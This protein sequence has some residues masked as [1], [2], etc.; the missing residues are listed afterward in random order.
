M[1]S[2]SEGTPKVPAA[3]ERFLKQ[4]VV[5][6][7]AVVLYPPASSIPQENAAACV[8]LLSKALRDVPEVR[9]AVNKTG[10][11]YEGIIVF[12]GQP[13][14]DSFAQEMYNRGLAEVRF[15]SGVSPS[16]VLGF[17]GTLALPP[18]DLAAAGGFESRLWESGVDA[19]TVKEASARIV[20]AATMTGGEPGEPGEPWPPAP[21]RIDEILA[22]AMGGRPRDQ[23]LIVRVISDAEAVNAY[24]VQT[25]TGR[26]EDPARMLAELKITELARM[27]AHAEQSMRPKLFR[28]LADAVGMLDPELRK[29]VLMEKMLPEARSDD[30][31]A[32]VVRQ[33]DIGEVCKLLVQGMTDD[34]ASVEGLARAIRN[35]ALISLADRDQVIDAAGAAMRESGLGES[36]IGAVFEEVSPTV[37]RVRDRA[38]AAVDDQ[39]VEQV[40]RLVDLAPGEITH[41]FDDDPD[42]LALQDEA[43]LG[44]NDGD[45]VGAL[46]T[47]VAVDPN[48]VNFASMMSLLEDNLEL[49]IERGDYDVAADVAQ[50]LA[51]VIDD[52]DLAPERKE[53]ISA[54]LGKLT[55]KA[56]IAAVTRALRMY[57]PGSGEYEAC[58]RLIATL[59]SGA[60]DPLLEVL[61]DEPDM[62]ARKGLV[63][64][65]SGM[66]SDYIDNLAV[67][68]SDPRWYFVRNVVAI[69]GSTKKSAALPA[70][71]RTLRHPDAR[72]RRETIRAVSGIQD[73][74]A[75]EMLVGALD[76][77]DAQNVQLAARYLGAAGV[78]AAVPALEMV[79][80]GEG[81]GNRDV[82]PR[83]EAIES[84]GRLGSAASLPLLESI[85]GKRALIGRATARELRSAAEDAI[86][87]IRG[88]RGGAR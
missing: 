65:L 77:G 32:S 2:G 19:I 11:G 46:V 61:A 45:V 31:M 7:K 64:L 79:A 73:R 37:L 13:A 35:L 30:A 36:V 12:E 17:L 56:E 66:A 40:L 49:T 54:A 50:S 29:M 16:D 83:T 38:E 9:F 76:D 68:V 85:A 27:A 63:D 51:I 82:G 1:D 81:R 70:L 72:V 44:I 42:F 26:G 71:G 75:T 80:R 20:D 33:M 47:L 22:A 84:L 10:L 87:R 43:R 60:V 41:R 62:T 55:G 8:T 57:R 34:A 78:G 86:A 74:L 25:L 18:A 4:L 52:P 48:G 58:R 21:S 53:R 24:F 5:T 3:I 39:P 6:M 69:L 59:G 88:S 28:A 14:F 15:H 23:R 67:R